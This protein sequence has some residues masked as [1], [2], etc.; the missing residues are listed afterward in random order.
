MIELTEWLPDLPDYKNPGITEALNV[1]PATKS[2]KPLNS[3]SVHSAALAERALGATAAKQSNGTTYD[4]VGTATYLYNLEAAATWEDVSIAGNYSTGADES[5]R[6]AQWGNQ[7]LA[8]NYSDEIQEYTLGTSTN[9]AILHASAPKARYIATTSDFVIVGNTF[10]SVDGNR[11]NRVRWSAIGAPGSSWAV[12]ATTQADYQDLDADNGWVQ[13]V[14]SGD[15]VYV[16]QERAIT[17]FRYVGS[18]KIFDPDVVEPERGCYIPNSIVQLGNLVYFLAEDGFYVFDGTKAIP[19]GE[20]KV[21]KTFFSD[22]GQTYK[23]RMSATLDPINKLIIWAYPS[24]LSNGELDKLIIYNW[25]ENKWSQA[26]VTLELLWRSTSLGYTLDGLDAISTNI[27]TMTDSFDARIWLG[28]ANSLTAIDTSHQMAYFTG[29]QLAGVI[30]TSEDEMNPGQ[31]TLVKRVRPMM[32][33]T[34]TLQVGTRNL[35]TESVTWGSELSPDSIGECQPLSNAR[36]HRFRFNS[37]TGL[38]HIQGLEI[39]EYSKLGRF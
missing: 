36:F 21:D 1:F 22:L 16:F 18:P 26:E 19:I 27:D 11:P 35:Q 30:E 33:G 13:G 39:A 20:G 2:Y 28:G 38:S 4:F 8:T 15:D 17:R 12:S 23:D 32:D 25:V 29:S 7:V 34:F 3:L 37:S 9:F 31:R 24:T 5:W 6:F 10:D 14:V